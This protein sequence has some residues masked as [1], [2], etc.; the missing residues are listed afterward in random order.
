MLSNVIYC[1]KYKIIEKQNGDKVS[2]QTYDYAYLLFVAH[3]LI[4]A[5]IEVRDLLQY[6]YQLLPSSLISASKFKYKFII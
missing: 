3:E 1:I 6:Q 5:R 4:W 2:I